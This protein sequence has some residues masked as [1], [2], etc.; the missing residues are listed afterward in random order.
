MASDEAHLTIGEVSEITGVNAVTLRAWQRRFGLV[1]PQRSP[2]GHR[3]YTEQNVDQIL[4]ITRWLDKGVA[5][6]KVKPL[7][8]QID[9]AG[10]GKNNADDSTADVW[11]DME[12][13]FI[14]SCLTVNEG[15][16]HNILDEA[17]SLYPVAVVHRKL[18]RPS[19]E[20]LLSLWLQRVDGDLLSAWLY[21]ELSARFSRFAMSKATP[22]KMKVAVID[23]GQVERWE[24]LLLR[25]ELLQLNIAVVDFAQQPIDVLPLLGDNWRIEAVLLC[26]GAHLTKADETKLLSVFQ[27]GSRPFY[28]V[29]QL[30]P[31]LLSLQDCVLPTL[32]GLTTKA[33]PKLVRDVTPASV[34]AVSAHTSLRK[35]L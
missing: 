27:A 33:Q 7:L 13:A 26:I 18:L 1:N 22:W 32:L 3:L 17:F 19:I 20:H 2:K 25:A 15:Q 30:A 28:L 24:S 14:Q 31:S 35:S 10:A 21:G 9:V 16:L 11:E 29:G 8:N 5:I 12:R 34:E 6:S 23:I 4:E